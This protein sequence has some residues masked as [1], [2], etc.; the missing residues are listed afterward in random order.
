[1][2]EKAFRIKVVEKLVMNKY[3]MFNDLFGRLKDFRDKT[4]TLNCPEF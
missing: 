1:M 3:F 2:E 4:K